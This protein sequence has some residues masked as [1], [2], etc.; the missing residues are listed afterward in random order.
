MIE[1]APEHVWDMLI[2][3]VRYA[4]HRRSMAPSTCEDLLIYAKHI[5]PWQRE[6]IRDEIAR[7]LQIAEDSGST[8]GDLCDHNTW[9]RCVAYLDTLCSED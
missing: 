3:S 4:L 2:F 6:Q 1:I 5:K 7:E 9:R 8:V